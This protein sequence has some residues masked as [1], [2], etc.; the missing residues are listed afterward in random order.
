MTRLVTVFYLSLLFPVYVIATP[1]AM[2]AGQRTS[3]QDTSHTTP[4]ER[5]TTSQKKVYVGEYAVEATLWTSY[6]DS[7]DDD[8]SENG[9]ADDNGLKRITDNSLQR[10]ADN[11]LQR[12]ADNSLK[13]VEGNHSERVADN[14]LKKVEGNHS[15]RVADN[16]L[17]RVEGNRSERVADIRSERVADIRSEMVADSSLKRIA[18]NSSKRVAGKKSEKSADN[19]S[20]QVADKFRNTLELLLPWSLRM[21]RLVEFEYNPWRQP[22]EPLS[23]VRVAEMEK[24][25]WQESMSFQV[26]KLTSMVGAPSGDKHTDFYYRIDIRMYPAKLRTKIYHSYDEHTFY[27]KKTVF[28]AK[29][30]ALGLEDAMHLEGFCTYSRTRNGR[31]E[32]KTFVEFIDGLYGRKETKLLEEEIKRFADDPVWQQNKRKIR[33]VDLPEERV[34]LFDKNPITALRAKYALK[35]A[36]E[37]KVAA[38]EGSEKSYAT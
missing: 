29:P 10:A 15:E 16:S 6:D 14:S 21:R 4:T 28:D 13:K 18:A 30:T 31:E 34:F 11:S 37:K 38:S 12:A 17:K 2:T 20:D 35:K 8:T 9:V 27:L 19:I 3:A 23:N 1:I 22:D 5:P 26:T 25:L 36:A 24:A 7:E 33:K 32:Q